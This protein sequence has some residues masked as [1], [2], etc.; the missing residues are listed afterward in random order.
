MEN[1]MSEGELNAFKQH[2]GPEKQALIKQG[3]TGIAYKNELEDKGSTS[4]LIWSPSAIVRTG[5]SFDI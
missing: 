3:Y 2:S 1:P 5:E 4:L